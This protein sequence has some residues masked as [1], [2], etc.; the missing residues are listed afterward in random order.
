[1]MIQ[2]SNMPIYSITRTAVKKAK[3]SERAD[4]SA[5]AFRRKDCS[6]FDHHITADG[7]HLAVGKPVEY[8]G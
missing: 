6:E 1:M 2:R 7:P 8:T 4:L 5:R 3:P